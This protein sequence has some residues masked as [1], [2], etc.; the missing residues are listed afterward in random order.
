[1]DT[2]VDAC[3]RHPDRQGGIICQRCDR[4]ICPQCM[5]QASVGFHCPECTKAG[6][7][8]VYSGPA[9]YRVDPVLTKVLVA[10]NVAIYVLGIAMSGGDAVMGRRITEVQADYGLWAGGI[11]G[12]EWYRLVTSGFLHD[13]LIHIGFNMWILWLVG[14]AVEQMGG[15]ARMG[16]IY[17]ASMLAGSLGALLFNP[18]SLTVGASG[19]I[20][21]LVGA[22]LVGQRKRGVA[23]RDSPLLGFVVL[24]AIITVTIPGISLGGHLGGFLGGAVAGWALLDLA[25]RRKGEVPPAVPWVITA[26]VAGLS[27]VGAI[28]VSDRWVTS[29]ILGFL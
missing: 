24:N 18:G 20:F 22:T 9:A 23:L 13:G 3:Y 4:P 25:D 11:F 29:Q 5:H 19:A 7:Q 1:M 28:V 12:D 15:R 2:H 27:I 6:A 26:A 14:Q 21:G 17:F 8:K 10:I 16:A